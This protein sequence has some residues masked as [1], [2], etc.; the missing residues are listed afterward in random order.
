[1]IMRAIWKRHGHGPGVPGEVAPRRR[2]CS[3]EVIRIQ[4]TAGEGELP[5]TSEFREALAHSLPQPR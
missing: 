1:M 4:E 5:E 3:R 2:A